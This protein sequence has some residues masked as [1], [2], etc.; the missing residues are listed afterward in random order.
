[1]SPLRCLVGSEAHLDELR[2][3]EHCVHLLQFLV[4]LVQNNVQG[5]LG[6]AGEDGVLQVEIVRL[7][8]LVTSVGSSVAP[9]H[10][11][12]HPLGVV[13]PLSGEVGNECWVRAL[14]LIAE[15]AE[16]L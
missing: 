15:L 8:L 2:R 13:R 6:D 3:C 5:S 16:Q 11:P 10:R 12:R 9:T 14:K 7:A 1:M 4:E